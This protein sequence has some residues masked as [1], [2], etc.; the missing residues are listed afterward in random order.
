M[1][2]LKAWFGR[3]WT[4]LIAARG[5]HP[6][7]RLRLAALYGGLVL[8]AGIVLLALTYGLV[9]A[10]GSVKIAIGVHSGGVLKIPPTLPLLPGTALYIRSGGVQRL[11]AGSGSGGPPSGPLAGSATSQLRGALL[12]AVQFQQTVDR[13][14]LLILGGIALLLVTILA[15]LA[16]WLVAG[17]ILRPLQIM[18]S[19]ARR[20]S[21]E[22]PGGR[23]ALG[24]P[25]DEIKDLADTFDAFLDRIDRALAAERRFVANAS[26]ELR[27]PLAVQKTLL[28]VGLSDHD[29]DATT[30]REMADRLW[31][32]NQRSRR[33]IEGLLEL[34]KSE[35]GLSAAE[36]V[37][38]SAV[39]H[40]E[41]EAVQPEAAAGDITVEEELEPGEVLGDRV[42]LGRLAGNLIENAVRH[43]LPGGWVQVRVQTGEAHVTLT[44]TNTGPIVAADGVASLFEPFRRAATD[45]TGSARGAGLGLA[46]ARAVVQAHKG[47]IEAEAR[48]GGGLQV[49]V[50]LPRVQPEAS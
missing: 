28:E 38:V 46:I 45:R 33:L 50:R 5:I 20:L 35:Q 49:T 23:F 29:A 19:T 22:T 41:V 47:S 16:G 11:V 24:G 34:A 27:T 15:F 13:Q 14:A 31:H 40:E 6:S 12:S 1:R 43:N 21:T 32:L 8:L 42:L 18:T 9:A 26:H 25:R 4:G 17:R 37:E 39:V 30:L 48:P 44:V 2:S 3:R 10:R 7:I 36:G